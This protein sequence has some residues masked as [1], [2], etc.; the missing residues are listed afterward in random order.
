MLPKL[1]LLRGQHPL[2]SP[3]IAETTHFLSFGWLE[4]HVLEP[5][6]SMAGLEVE[7]SN[8]HKGSRGPEMSVTADGG[9]SGS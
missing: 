5:A 9:G 7:A 6:N 8:A 4:P 3:D 2:I 1:N